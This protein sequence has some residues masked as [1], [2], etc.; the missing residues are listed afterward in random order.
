MNDWRNWYTVYS[1]WVSPFSQL[2][3]FEHP[4]SLHTVVS[5]CSTGTYL[6]GTSELEQTLPQHWDSL[7]LPNLHFVSLSWF[8]SVQ[9]FKHLKE[10]QSSVTEVNVAMVDHNAA[11]KISSPTPSIKPFMRASLCVYGSELRYT[12]FMTAPL[13]S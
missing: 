1:R 8:I 10:W 13:A 2:R 11:P 4:E 5:E 12:P 9:S 6:F 3:S 7:H